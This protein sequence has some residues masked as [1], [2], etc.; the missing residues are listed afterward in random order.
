DDGGGGA[1]G[2]ATGVEGAGGGW[3]AAFPVEWGQALGPRLLP[4]HT[5]REGLERVSHWVGCQDRQTGRRRLMSETNGERSTRE[6]ASTRAITRDRYDAVLL[7]L[8]GVIT[9]TASIHAASW[10]N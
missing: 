3:G 6:P 7:D 1:G 2:G 5:R 10:K 4:R 8:D 9:D